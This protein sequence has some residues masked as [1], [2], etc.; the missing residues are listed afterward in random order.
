MFSGASTVDS[1]AS[2]KKV[3]SVKL[4]SVSST[5]GSEAEDLTRPL[6]N[7]QQQPKEASVFDGLECQIPDLVTLSLLPKSQWQSLIHL[8]IIKVCLLFYSIHVWLQCISIHR[9]FDWGLGDIKCFLCLCYHNQV[10]NKPVEPPKKPEKAPFFL[11]SVPTLSGEIL[12][13]PSEPTNEEAKKDDQSEIR[14]K[15]S[16]T[17]SSQFFRFLNSAAEIKNCELNICRFYLALMNGAMQMIWEYILT[18]WSSFC[19]TLHCII[20]HKCSFGFYGLHERLV[21]ISTG[22]GTPNAS[23]PRWRWS[24]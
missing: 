16:D 7:P 12:F 22:H 4:P 24:S 6:E 2:G 14:A 20:V 19:R 21:S 1:Y 11:P 3:V 23:D 5:N 18:G 13:K 10:R 9:T 15:Q 17:A 8:D